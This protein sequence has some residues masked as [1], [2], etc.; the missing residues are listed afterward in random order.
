MFANEISNLLYCCEKAHRF[1][2]NYLGC[3]RGG[4]CFLSPI[5]FAEKL[6]YVTK[7]AINLF[8]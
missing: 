6:F 4:M 1:V 5:L 2:Y 3:A 8:M 7:A